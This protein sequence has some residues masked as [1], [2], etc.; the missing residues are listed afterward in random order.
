[1]DAALCIP[2]RQLSGLCDD[3]AEAV[4]VQAATGDAL[5]QAR[6]LGDMLRCLLQLSLDPSGLALTTDLEVWK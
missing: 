5:L 2:V 4:T 1:M 6:G 3:A